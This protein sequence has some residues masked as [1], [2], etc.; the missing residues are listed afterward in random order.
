MK[1]PKIGNQEHLEKKE[2]LYYPNGQE[3]AV[4]IHIL[5]NGECAKCWEEDGNNFT[6]GNKVYKRIWHTGI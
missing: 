4:V 6:D 5:S 2:Y 3:K 1:E